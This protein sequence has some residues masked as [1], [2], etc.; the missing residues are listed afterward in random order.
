[1]SITEQHAY[2]HPVGIVCNLIPQHSNICVCVCVCM[3]V[4]VCVCV[5]MYKHRCHGVHRGQ[6]GDHVLVEVI[7]WRQSSDSFFA[8]VLTSAY[9]ITSASLGYAAHSSSRGV[10]E[11][12]EV[13]GTP[14]PG[15][16]RMPYPGTQGHHTCIPWTLKDT[17]PD[18]QGHRTGP[19]RTPYRTLKDTIPWTLKDTVPDPQGHHTLDTQVASANIRAGGGGG[20]E[21]ELSL[22]HPW[23]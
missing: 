2:T 19:S 3:C 15:H 16:S 20:A 1:M 21:E 14:Y 17:V 6:I 13:M 7:T 11:F 10:F 18:P 5:R 9:V 23:R 22:Y 12:G 8:S 4:C